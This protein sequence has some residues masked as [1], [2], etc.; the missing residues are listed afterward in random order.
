[1]GDQFW[2]RAAGIAMNH[3]AGDDLTVLKSSLL[4]FPS[5]FK[6]SVIGI[7]PKNKI[8]LRVAHGKVEACREPNSLLGS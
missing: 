4:T 5:A 3:K 7:E 2:K 1:M 6:R 8:A